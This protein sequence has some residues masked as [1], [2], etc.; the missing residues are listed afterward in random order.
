M[1]RLQMKYGR[2]EEIQN[3]SGFPDKVKQF[4]LS[5]MGIQACTDQ[6]KLYGHGNK[7]QL[8]VLRN[9]KPFKKSQ[10]EGR[11]FRHLL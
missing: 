9:R 3:H 11:K 8:L 6:H 7:P 1:R 10:E 4:Y 2:L 5:G